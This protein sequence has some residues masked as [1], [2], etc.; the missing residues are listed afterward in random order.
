MKNLSKDEYFALL[1]EESIRTYLA[2]QPFNPDTLMEVKYRAGVK[3]AEAKTEFE[4]LTW[5]EISSII[6]RNL[7]NIKSPE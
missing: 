1:L 3:A 5:T 6:D 4:R 2:S 7:D